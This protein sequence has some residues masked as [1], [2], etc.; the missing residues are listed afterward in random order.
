MRLRYRVFL[1]YFQGGALGDPP[2]SRY[3]ELLLACNAYHRLVAENEKTG[4]GREVELWD[5]AVGQCLMST[6]EN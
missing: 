4:S 1:C 3:R 6:W 2:P 5:D